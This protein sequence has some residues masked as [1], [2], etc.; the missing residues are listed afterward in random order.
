MLEQSRERRFE[1]VEWE[2]PHPSERAADDRGVFTLDSRSNQGQR[3]RCLAGPEILQRA[4]SHVDG[5]ARIARRSFEKAQHGFA[6]RRFRL[7]PEGTVSGREEAD[8]V[9]KQLTERDSIGETS[10]EGV[11]LAIVE[12]QRLEELERGTTVAKQVTRDV[13]AKHRALVREQ[14]RDDRVVETRH[15][16]R[17]GCDA[18]GGAVQIRPVV[19]AALG[20]DSP[21]ELHE[22]WVFDP[23]RRLHDVRRASTIRRPGAP[24]SHPSIVPARR[25]VTRRVLRAISP[26]SCRR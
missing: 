18:F 15:E 21:D 25:R 11:E 7:A 4:P 1:L 12:E 24:T 17:E 8:F 16:L 3:A 13:P 2:K 23:Q 19:E 10:G 20:H 14:R 5:E 26:R 9:A 6:A 22:R